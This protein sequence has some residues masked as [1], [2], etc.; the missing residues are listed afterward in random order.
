RRSEYPNRLARGA[1]SLRVERRHDLRPSGRGRPARGG[2][3]LSQRSPRP[4]AGGGPRCYCNLVGR[5]WRR[6]S[7]PRPGFR[8]PF[9]SGPGGEGL[10]GGRLVVPGDGGLTP[11]VVVE[12]SNP[13]LTGMTGGIASARVTRRSPMRLGKSWLV[14]LGLAG[15][16]F[17]TIY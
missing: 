17:V 15:G 4:G 2:K 6:A 16:S 14:F 3:G 7:A 5:G 13:V 1:C 12:L 9:A 10:A 11:L 8:H